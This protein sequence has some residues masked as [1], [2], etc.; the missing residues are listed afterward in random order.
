MRLVVIGDGESPHLLKWV[1]ALAAI[2]EQ[3]ELFAV[4]S[5][6]FVPGIEELVPD[7]RRLSL[8]QVMPPQ[9]GNTTL[10]RQLPLLATWLRSVQ[11][12]WLAPHYL[13]SHGTLA[14]LAVRVLGVRA[15]IA[16][17]AWGTD[18]LV[19]PERSR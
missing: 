12:D 15:R 6:G 9:S 19:T 7:A 5:R 4:S 18:I 11:P 8:G 14:W 13:T 16:G 10:L 2:P 17:S 3:V 1:R